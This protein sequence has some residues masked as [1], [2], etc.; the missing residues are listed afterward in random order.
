MTG[1][2][3]DDYADILDRPHHVSRVHP[4]M[5]LLDRAAQFSPFAALTGYG[6]AVEETARYVDRKRVPDEESV[7]RIDEVL[8]GLAPGDDVTVEY[9]RPDVRKSGGVYRTVTGRV[10]KADPRKGELVLEDRSI[11]F[12]DIWFLTGAGELRGGNDE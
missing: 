9:F 1:S 5:S 7:L 10:K 6:D 4:P 3:R 12:G 8:R 2:A 11:P